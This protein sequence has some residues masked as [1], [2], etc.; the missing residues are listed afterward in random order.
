VAFRQMNGIT[1]KRSRPQSATAIASV[2]SVRRRS[3]PPEAP[4]RAAARMAV[5]IQ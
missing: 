1:A 3:S 2:T 4:S 5:P